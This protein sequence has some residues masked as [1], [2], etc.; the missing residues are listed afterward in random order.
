MNEKENKHDP[1]RWSMGSKHSQPYHCQNLRNDRNTDVPDRNKSGYDKNAQDTR[2]FARYFNDSTLECRGVIYLLEI[3]R[4][5]QIAQP[6]PDR[7][8]RYD[9]IE[10]KQGLFSCIF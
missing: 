8:K 4:K 7:A 2:D 9:D 1:K 6:V 3:I 10:N 5:N